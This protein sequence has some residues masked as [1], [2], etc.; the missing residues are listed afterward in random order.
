MGRWFRAGKMRKPFASRSAPRSAQPES[1]LRRSHACGA[2]YRERVRVRVGAALFSHAHARTRCASEP[3]F[4]CRNIST[5]V[6]GIDTLV[7]MEQS[8]LRPNQEANCQRAKCGWQKFIASLERTCATLPA[9][10]RRARRE[11]AQPS[12]HGRAGAP[13]SVDRSANTCGRRR[14]LR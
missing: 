3:G 8:G 14:R 12:L 11:A 9:S 6:P 5:P 7:R 4:E 13:D 1:P 10:E 2:D